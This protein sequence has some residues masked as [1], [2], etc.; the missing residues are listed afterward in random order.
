MEPM[1]IWVARSLLETLNEVRRR[2]SAKTKDDSRLDIFNS[3]NYIKPF[4][5]RIDYLSI[6]DQA[7]R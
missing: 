5:F 3:W 6:L 1:I 7:D 4:L 2:D